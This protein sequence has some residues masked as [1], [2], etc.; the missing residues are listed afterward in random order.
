MT[1]E[2]MQRHPGSQGRTLGHR[3]KLL[4]HSDQETFVERHQATF[5]M[6]RLRSS[7]AIPKWPTGEHRNERRSSLELVDLRGPTMLGQP[8]ILM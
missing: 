7:L 8:E 4:I 1:D 6:Q 5:F 2:F 3:F